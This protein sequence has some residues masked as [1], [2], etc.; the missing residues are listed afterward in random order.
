MFEKS[1][2]KK[3]VKTVKE[4]TDLTAYVDCETNCWRQPVKRRLKTANLR[5]IQRPDQFNG[6]LPEIT[7]EFE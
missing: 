4:M 7:F 6:V 1:L 2:A 5:W 3:F